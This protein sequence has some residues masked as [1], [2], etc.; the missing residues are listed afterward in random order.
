MIIFKKSQPQLL[1][2]L[3]FTLFYGCYTSNI[4][5][6]TTKI[7]KS[8]DYENLSIGDSMIIHM[9]KEAKEIDHTGRS[10]QGR[11]LT[12]RDH[13]RLAEIVRSGSGKIFVKTCINRDGLS[14][15]VEI[16]KQNTTI[17]NDQALGNA[18]R[19][20]LN[21]TFEADTLAPPYECGTLKLFL[22]V[23]PF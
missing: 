14:E 8:I 7:D 6:R 18:L 11:R 4:S 21:Y 22:D 23:D 15:Y 13:S 10:I 17:T 16:D 1:V 12:Y 3:L 19:M 9:A 2:V 20:I 5:Q